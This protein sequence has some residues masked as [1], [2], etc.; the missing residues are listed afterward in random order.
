M[1]KATTINLIKETVH[2]PLNYSD[3]SE[4]IIREYTNCYAHAIG[5]TIPDDKGTYRLGIISGK[6]KSIFGYSSIE[7]VKNF[8]LEDMK[9]LELG[10]EE[11]EIFKEELIGNEK[12]FIKEKQH[13]VVLF[14]E[15]RRKDMPI[16]EFHFFRY[17]TEMGWTEKRYG[18]ISLP[19]NTNIGWLDRWPYIQV[20]IFR[21]TR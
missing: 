14:A 13:I 19:V 9:T 12:N 1:D 10:V 15:K 11:L 17:D 4:T 7:E 21:I 5:S 3:Y 8:F 20:G 18:T 16:M 6:R 2:K